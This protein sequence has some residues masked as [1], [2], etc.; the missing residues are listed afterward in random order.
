MGGNGFG[1]VKGVVVLR[2]VWMNF[3]FNIDLSLML[4]VYVVCFVVCWVEKGECVDVLL[5][6]LLCGLSGVDWGCS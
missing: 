4:W 2:L 1:F 6:S 3:F 5:E